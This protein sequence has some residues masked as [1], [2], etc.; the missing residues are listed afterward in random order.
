MDGGLQWQD[1]YSHED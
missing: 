1:P